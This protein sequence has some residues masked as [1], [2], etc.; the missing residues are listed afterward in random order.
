MHRKTGSSVVIPSEMAFIHAWVSRLLGA[1]PA[2]ASPVATSERPSDG[3]PFSVLCGTRCS[4]EWARPESTKV[5]QGAW[6]EGTRSHVLRWTD[7]E[8]AL[9]C[10]LE[11]T[12]FL[13]FPAVEWVVR[14]RNDGS[15]DSPPV[16]GFNALDIVWR[17]ARAGDVPELRRSLGSDGRHDD[18]QYQ[19]RELRQSMWSVPCTVRMDTEQNNAF[20]KVRNG[21]CLPTDGRPSAT[22][23]PFF[24]LRTGE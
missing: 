10:E 15:A 6:R 17:C 21:S 24:N 11:L 20:R 7:G 8:T 23:L 2:G 22:W 16:S 9:T 3:P 4:R 12:E 13:D 19:C 14:L 1:V 5:E 18:F